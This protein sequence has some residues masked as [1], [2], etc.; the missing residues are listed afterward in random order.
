MGREST[1]SDGPLA[2]YVRRKA[3]RQREAH[4]VA[5]ANDRLSTA[6]LLTFVGGIV[7]TGMLFHYEIPAVIGV[8]T[9]LAAVALF[10]T[11]VV[12]H[13][14][15]K[16][17]LDRLQRAIAHYDWGCA[18]IEDR[19]RGKGITGVRYRDPNHLYAEDLDL[20]GEGSLFELLATARTRMGERAIA[21]WLNGTASPDE[22]RVRQEA[23]EELR[24]ELDLREDLA[25][26]GGEVQEELDPEAMMAW[27]TEPR[28]FERNR[29]RRG[30]YGLSIVM[31]LAIVAS[32]FHGA[33]LTLP[34]LLYI[35]ELLV[36]QLVRKRLE[37][38]LSK[39]TGL[40]RHLTLL[41]LLLARIE[42]SSLQSPR[43]V[44][45][46]ERLG[47]AGDPPTRE[48]ARLAR[49][50]ALFESATRNA[51]VAL[52]AVI[53]LGPIHIAYALEAWWRR[54]GPHIPNGW[55]Q[56]GNSKPFRPWVDMRMSTPM[57]RSPRSWRVGLF[58]TA[59]AWSTPSSR[60][61]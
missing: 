50:I 42:E 46:R 32:Q 51:I 26:I 16:R 14:R 47:T 6:R 5:R 4:R 30:A 60:G 13:T 20:F 31:I 61:T 53:I 17:H 10:I 25:V 3:E 7:L 41:R 27:S 55:K 23:I 24:D 12:L 2:V 36:L 37:T 34:M 1:V 40:G 19:W 39:A 21:S 28:Q 52:V 29:L 11:L 49:L 58:S 48:I 33:L 15:G 45:L 59:R 57:I 22:I 9:A 38:L 8:A 43:L 56:S 18:R 35:I 54:V 44:A